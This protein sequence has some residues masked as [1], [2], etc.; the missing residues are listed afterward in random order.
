M[1]ECKICGGKTRVIRDQQFNIDYFKC[2]DCDFIHMEEGKRVSFEEERAVYDLHENSIEN[3]G[4]I[5]MFRN[6]IDKAIIPFKSEGRGLDF[7][8]GPEPVLTQLIN[9]DYD[10]Q[11]ENYDLHYQPEKIYQGKKYDLIVSTEVVEHLVDPMD[12]FNLI[13]NHLEEDGIFAFM[14]I[15]HD[16]NDDSFKKWWYRRD[17]THI[18]FY[19][20]RTLKEI[21]SKIGF[22][23]I[24]SD[25][26]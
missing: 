10:F 14:T 25:N 2:L 9:R 22:E 18:S 21:A 3:E 4:Y 16:N 13:Y 12:V 17:E 20:E 24:Y 11:M 15:L 7:G 1:L 26:K 6:F 5:N 23:F 8:S 19:S